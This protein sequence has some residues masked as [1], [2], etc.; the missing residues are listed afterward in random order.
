MF[1][2]GLPEQLPLHYG[3]IVPVTEWTQYPGSTAAAAKFVHSAAGVVLPPL[4]TGIAS[5]VEILPAS[6]G[7]I[8]VHPQRH[9]GKPYAPQPP[10]VGGLMADLVSNTPYSRGQGVGL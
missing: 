4:P 10:Y 9:P 1:G 8:M 6:L 5:Q 7:P 3:E 2:N